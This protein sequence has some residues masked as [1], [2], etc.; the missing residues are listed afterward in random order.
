MLSMSQVGRQLIEVGSVP[1]SHGPWGSNSGREP[2]M[3][4]LSPNLPFPWLRKHDLCCMLAEIEADW[5][6]QTNKQKYNLSIS[7][8]VRSC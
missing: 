8:I 2:S 1:P 6:K 7:E 5:I 3:P 4:G